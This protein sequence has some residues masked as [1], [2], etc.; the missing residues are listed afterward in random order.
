MAVPHMRIDSAAGVDL[1]YMDGDEDDD[2]E[3]GEDNEDDDGNT[4]A[5]TVDAALIALAAAAAQHEQQVRA[6]AHFCANSCTDACHNHRRT[7]DT[8]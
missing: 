3:E 6:S 8:Y 7:P 5:V 1:Q 2:D 4:D